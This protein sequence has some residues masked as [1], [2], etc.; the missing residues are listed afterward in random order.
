M[1]LLSGDHSIGDKSRDSSKS[2][3]EL[4]QADISD[5]NTT[6]LGKFYGG[7]HISLPDLA[8]ELHKSWQT[9]GS[10]KI[11]SLS[12][13]FYKMVFENAEEY[14]HVRKNGPWLIQGFIISIQKWKNIERL[15]EEQ[16]FD[17]VDFWVQ[18]YGLPSN[19]INDENV[20]KVGLSLGKVKDVDLLCS[21]EFKKPVARGPVSVTISGTPQKPRPMVTEERESS[22]T[23]VRTDTSE[24]TTVGSVTVG[25]SGLGGP[26]SSVVVIRL[27]LL[28]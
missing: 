3:I 23:E 8:D 27:G 24:H 14:E 19:R 13:G 7:K 1:N 12:K 22:L 4:L 6:L 10:T 16:K 9:R 26:N 11:E 15:E 18:I 21:S 28:A 2:R 5:G 25:T 17:M 20:H